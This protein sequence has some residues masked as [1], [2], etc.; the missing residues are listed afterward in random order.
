MALFSAGTI[1]PA[2]TL[3]IA[4]DP[5]DERRIA[6][7]WALVTSAIGSV[8]IGVNI[9]MPTDLTPALYVMPLPVIFGIAA[10][11]ANRPEIS[12]R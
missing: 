3:L 7:V 6:L 5:G 2:W 10:W 4:A 9:F 8:A 1:I 11:L 12:E